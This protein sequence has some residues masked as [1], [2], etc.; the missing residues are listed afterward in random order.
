[1]HINYK[2]NLYY[3]IFYFHDRSSYF[4]KREKKEYF[5]EVGIFQISSFDSH[6]LQTLIYNYSLINFLPQV[7][8]FL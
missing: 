4:F 7:I 5:S 3:I 2:I 8:P 1:M 6:W